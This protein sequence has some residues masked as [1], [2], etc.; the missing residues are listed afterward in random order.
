MT[1]IYEWC[2]FYV[3]CIPQPNLHCLVVQKTRSLTGYDAELRPLY[4]MIS[5]LFHGHK[6]WYTLP[7]AVSSG[8]QTLHDLASDLA[9][10]TI[11][12]GSPR[13]ASYKRHT[14]VP[15]G[16]GRGVVVSAPTG[17]GKTLLLHQLMEA[18]TCVCYGQ[19]I[20][21]LATLMHMAAAKSVFI[22][23]CQCYDM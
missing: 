18:Y 21:K 7:A 15:S 2:I 20:T 12:S 3:L 19:P 1:D 5:V 6:S 4:D 8:D 13:V 22:G 10:C 23:P 14:A 17:C 9:S 16:V 11:Q